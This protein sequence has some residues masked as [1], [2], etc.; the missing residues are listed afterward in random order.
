MIHNQVS[1]EISVE[2]GEL[3]N[4]LAVELPHLQEKLAAHHVTAANIVLNNQSGG[5]AADSRQAYRQSAHTTQRSTSASGESKA[6]PGIMSIADSQIPS[7]QLD[8]HM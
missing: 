3:H 2:R 8:V 1:A 7:T 4:L 6:V 5:N